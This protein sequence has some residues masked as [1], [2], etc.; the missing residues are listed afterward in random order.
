MSNLKIC[1]VEGGVEM[2][3]K[4]VRK[5]FNEII[6]ENSPNLGKDIDIEGYRTSNR[7]DQ[8]RSSEHHLL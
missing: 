6:A 5:Q 7:L 2:Q 1:G 4:S 8:D 3:T